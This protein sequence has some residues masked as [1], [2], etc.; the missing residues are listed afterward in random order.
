MGDEQVTLP[1]EEE[2]ARLPRNAVVAYAL[3]CAMRVRPLVEVYW[4]NA[5]RKQL[6]AIDRAITLVQAA[7]TNPA[8]TSASELS[9]AAV[10]A[11]A[12]ANAADAANAAAARA[13][14]AAR[15]AAAAD[16]AH[17]AHAA[18]AAAAS[19]VAAANAAAGA[20]YNT[21][22]HLAREDGWADDTG[23]DV[24]R[25]GPLWPQGTPAGW[26]APHSPPAS[27]DEP[28]L[29]GSGVFVDRIGVDVWIDPG[30]ST[31]DDV[32]DVFAALSD[33]HRACGGQGLTF[34]ANP[35]TVYSVMGER[36]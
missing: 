33:Y 8:S 30:D 36:R 18:H 10:A 4:P 3:R 20:D 16:T 14:L 9:H 1:T 27:P 17:A 2:L 24:E 19:N 34:S 15:A 5:P 13:A 26:P 6:A 22:A 12:A 29:F 28:G 23:I 21:L 25:L 7:V 11:D 32:A 31:V 35:G